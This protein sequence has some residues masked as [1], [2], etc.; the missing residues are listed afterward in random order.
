MANPIEI[1]YIASSG[2]QAKIALSV[3]D[4]CSVNEAIEISGILQQFPEIDL[5]RQPVG[6]FGKKCPLSMSVSNGDRIEI[7][8]SL[9]YD[10]K[11]RRRMKAKPFK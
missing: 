8:R 10:P 7:Y 4:S 5:T 1:V 11:E 3:N 6:I 9:Q 2:K